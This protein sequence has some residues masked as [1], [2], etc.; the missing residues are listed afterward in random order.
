MPLVLVRKSGI[1]GSHDMHVTDVL[2][3]SSKFTFH[4]LLY[5][6]ETGPSKYCLLLAGEAL[7]VV[8]LEETLRGKELFSGSGVLSAHSYSTDS[9]SSTDCF[10]RGSFSSA[11]GFCII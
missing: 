8:K 11:V 4:S 10:Q 3:P 7:P 6:N 2:S 1:V 9:F 5:K